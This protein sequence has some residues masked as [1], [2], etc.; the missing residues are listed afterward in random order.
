MDVLETTQASRR[1]GSSHVDDELLREKDAEIARLNKE[2]AMLRTARGSNR[3]LQANEDEEKNKKDAAKSM[4]YSVKKN[5]QSRKAQVKQ[6]QALT[7][8]IEESAASGDHAK[9]QSIIVS[10][11]DAI[12]AEEKSNSKMDR[13]MVNMIDFSTVYF[14]PSTTGTSENIDDLIAQNDKLHRKL[15]KPC[16][17]CGHKRSDKKDEQSHHNTAHETKDVGNSD[18]QKKS[19]KNMPSFDS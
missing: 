1:I 6:I 15:A 4:I 18:H 16:K 17:K 9:L 11:K 5:R 8:E 19:V 3:Q 10:L 7:N 2:V 14:T 12:Q 13:D